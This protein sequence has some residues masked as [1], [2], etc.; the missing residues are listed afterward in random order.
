MVA[1]RSSSACHRITS[2]LCGPWLRFPVRLRGDPRART[3][4]LSIP[5][6]P[7]ATPAAVQRCA[8]SALPVELGPRIQL[9]SRPPVGSSASPT[10][11]IR[12]YPRSFCLAW[13]R[14]L[15]VSTSPAGDLNLS[16][17]PRNP[18]GS[19]GSNGNLGGVGPPCSLCI[20][21]T[22]E[23]RVPLQGLPT[24]QAPLL[25]SRP[26][27]PLRPGFAMFTGSHCR[28]FTGF[29]RSSRVCRHSSIP[30]PRATI[31]YD[32]AALHLRVAGGSRSPA[33]PPLGGCSAN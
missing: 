33:L 21:C 20:E 12:W 31:R 28:P 2:I 4:N 11:T 29:T 17:S 18:G 5:V 10:P 25:A 1:S 23:V 16:L 3:W 13:P 7:R 22:P 8:P 32:S 30:Y 14:R 19:E 6:Y 26:T 27:Y 15:G 24:P 9:W